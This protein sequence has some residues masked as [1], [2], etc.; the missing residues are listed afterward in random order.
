MGSR[1]ART[2]RS[3]DSAL[4][5][6]QLLEP[7]ELVQLRL[8]PGAEPLAIDHVL[9]AHLRLAGLAAGPAVVD[10]DVVFNAIADRKFRDRSGFEVE[11]PAAF[12]AATHLHRVR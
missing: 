3:E 10:L 1:R 8:D 2:R 11:T 9:D 6:L 5:A 12:L 7:L 4:L